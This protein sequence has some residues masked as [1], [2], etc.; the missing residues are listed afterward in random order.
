MRRRILWLALCLIMIIAMLPTAFADGSEDNRRVFDEDDIL[1]DSE[2]AKLQEHI[3]K[4]KEKYNSD[5][6]IRVMNM[7]ITEESFQSFCMDYYNTESRG[8]HKFGD[9]GL[10]IILNMC[11]DDDGRDYVICGVAPE[12]QQP[13]LDEYFAEIAEEKGFLR[14]LQ[15]SAWFDAFDTVLN[16][17]EDFLEQAA[18]GE[19]FSKQNP[20]KEPKKPMSGT[21]FTILSIIEAGIALLIGKGYASGLRASMNTAIKRTEATEYIDKS[22]FNLARTSDMFMYSNVTRTPIP[23][24]TRSGGGGG[25][26]FG[27]SSGGHSFSGH[28]GHF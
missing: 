24:E 19:R 22:S 11:A 7:S 23:T 27:G 20:Y 2:E 16:L 3:D 15:N 14:N 18:T 6:V 28:S 8:S 5:T 12:G 1:S 26:S 17:S 4:I 10:M 21:K 13:I 25:S 9:D